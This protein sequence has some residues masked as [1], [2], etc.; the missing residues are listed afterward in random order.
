[1]HFQ[2]LRDAP[3]WL[4]QASGS[5]CPCE[6]RA[7]APEFRG[8]LSAS[9]PLRKFSSYSRSFHDPQALQGHVDSFP[10]GCL[11]HVPEV[12]SFL[13]GCGFVS[14]CSEE[15]LHLLSGLAPGLVG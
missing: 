6:S 12:S 8:L 10:C 2:G 7:V 5:L 11:V 3:P 15:T 1:M 4:K 14:L 13:L 9:L